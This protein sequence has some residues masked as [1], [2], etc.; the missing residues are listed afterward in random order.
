[1]LVSTT[2]RPQTPMEVS[3]QPCSVRNVWLTISSFWKLG[4][5]GVG[6]ARMGPRNSTPGTDVIG[7]DFRV[8]GVR[9]L[10]IVDSSVFPFVINGHT[11]GAVYIMAEKAAQLIL[12]SR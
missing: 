3:F 6:T 4:V 8:K 5:H 9:G 10:R 1:M 2:S 7:P 12:D 11:M